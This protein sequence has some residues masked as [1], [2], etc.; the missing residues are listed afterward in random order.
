VKSFRLEVESRRELIQN[1]LALLIG[2]GVFLALDRLGIA[3]IAWRVVILLSGAVFAGWLCRGRLCRVL[4]RRYPNARWIALLAVG[5]SVLA[6]GFL[7]RILFPW[8]EEGM[9]TPAFLVLSGGCVAAFLLV[10][11]RDPD[12]LK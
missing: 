4:R 8:A 11:R 12:V 7:A 3:E 5:L 1:G 10:N 9:F 2:A 6:F